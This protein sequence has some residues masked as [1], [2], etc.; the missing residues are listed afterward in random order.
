MAEVGRRA[1]SFQGD[2]WGLCPENTGFSFQREPI[3]ASQSISVPTLKI[4]SLNP[5]CPPAPSKDARCALCTPASRRPLIPTGVLAGEAGPSRCPAGPLAAP[6]GAQPWTFGGHSKIAQWAS[7][8]P[9]RKRKE[10]M[11]PERPGAPSLDLQIHFGKSTKQR[12]LLALLSMPLGP[13]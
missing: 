7:L 10:L 3:F 6:S 2:R 11:P 9:H 13:Q 12:P 4:P 5:P 1:A 8:G